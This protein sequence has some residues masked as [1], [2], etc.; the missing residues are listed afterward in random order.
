M[1]YMPQP[2]EPTSAPIKTFKDLLDWKPGQD[3][4]NVAHTPFHPRP[5]PFARRAESPFSSEFKD[6]STPGLSNQAQLR[7]CKVIVCHDMAGG[8]AE[9]ARPQGNDYDKIYSIQ[10]WNHVDIFIYFSHYRITIP[11][12]VWTN[13]A[14]R[15]GVR[16]IGT[17]I[18]EW[19]PGI[20]ETDEM[21]SGPNQTLADENGNDT[22]DRRWFS[23]TYA[24]KLVDLAVYYKFDGWFINIESIMRGGVQQVNQTIA[25]LKYFREQIHQRIPGGELHWYDS[26]ITSTGE[27]AWQDKLSPENYRFFEQ[28]DGI[29]TNYTWQEKAV[30]ESVALAGPRNRDVYTG[31]DIWGRNTF[32]GGGFTTYKALEII[33][34]ERTS[35]A[36]F[37]PAWTYESL[38]KDAFMTNDRLFWTGY[39]GAGFHAENLPLSSFYLTTCWMLATKPKK[40]ERKKKSDSDK[41]KD[42]EEDNSN[43]LPVSAY[44]PLRPSGCATWFYSNFDRG[45]GNKFWING[46]KVS[47]KAWSHLSHQSLSPSLSKEVFSIERGHDALPLPGTP[48]AV[49]WILSPENAYNGGTSLVVQEFSLDSSTPPLPPLPI[50]P[51]PESPPTLPPGR[52]ELKDAPAIHDATPLRAADIVHTTRTRSIIV[53]F[54]DIQISLLNALDSTVE[55]VFKSCQSDVQ[56]GVHLGILAAGEDKDDSEKSTTIACKLSR[57]ELLELLEPSIKAQWESIP[58]PPSAKKAKGFLSLGAIEGTDRSKQLETVLA[59]DIS[60]RE[61]GFVDAIETLEGGWRRLTLHISSLFSDAFRD[62]RQDDLSTIFLS[63]LGLTLTYE[64]QAVPSKAP[65]K[66]ESRAL[67]IIGSLAVVPTWNAVYKGSCVQGLKADE[68]QFVVVEK[69]DKSGATIDSAVQNQQQHTLGDISIHEQQQP[70]SIRPTMLVLKV[71]STVTWNIGYPIV[72]PALGASISNRPSSFVAGEVSPVDYSHYAVYLS[73]EPR[74]STI[75]SVRTSKV[76]GRGNGEKLF[77]GTAFTNQYQILQFEIPM[78]QVIPGYSSRLPDDA[79][80]TAPTTTSTTTDVQRLLTSVEVMDQSRRSI[81][82]WVQGIRRDGR[83][84]EPRDWAVGQLL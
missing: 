74:N 63:Q 45:F 48:K 65:E 81:W 62:K 25:F 19:L 20:L 75:D 53:P 13:A 66:E 11:P 31:I 24:D 33:Q 64:G 52:E 41:D 73:I 55:L 40:D 39:N 78:D 79:T 36:L 22:V 7:D 42:E 2:A 9:D 34:R 80:I 35:C 10:Y 6:R 30:G 50:P 3:E 67:V 14:H 27:I 4:Y 59:L 17:I 1:V 51:P 29:F 76:E 49:R 57:Q 69:N 46:K 16:S 37:A 8:Y 32:G 72:G 56:V 70:E 77:V 18:T 26:V 71:S 43:F 21:V 15:N 58:T 82:M 47:E 5:T 84:D 60:P 61:G 12:P 44:I 38:G 83:A 28:S 68:S 23:K 54:F